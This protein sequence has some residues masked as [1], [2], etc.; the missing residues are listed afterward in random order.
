MYEKI[1]KC[2]SKFKRLLHVPRS[3]PGH[4]LRVILLEVIRGLSATL[5]LLLSLTC[6]PKISLASSATNA[7]S[8]A[9]VSI[10][11]ESDDPNAFLTDKLRVDLPELLL[12]GY[13]EGGESLSNSDQT[14]DQAN[15]FARRDHKNE[16]SWLLDLLNNNHLDKNEALQVLDDDSDYSPNTDLIGRVCMTVEPYRSVLNELSSVE[17]EEKY[18]PDNKKTEKPHFSTE[19]NAFLECSPLSDTESADYGLDEKHLG[20]W[21][22]R[23]CPEALEF[24]ALKQKCVHT[25]DVKPDNCYISAKDDQEHLEPIT[26]IQ[27][28]SANGGEEFTSSEDLSSAFENVD[29]QKVKQNKRYRAMQWA[30]VTAGGCYAPCLDP[31]AIELPR[32]EGKCTW[33]GAPLQQDALSADYFLQC[34]SVHAGQPCGRWA[35]IQCPHGTVFNPAAQ[36]CVRQQGS[37]Q[38]APS[39][40][41]LPR[42]PLGA[43]MMPARVLPPQLLPPPPAIP[44][45]PMPILPEPV[46]F[47]PPA[48]TGVCP[49][50]SVAISLCGTKVIVDSNVPT[51]P[52]RAYCHQGTCCSPVG[53]DIKVTLP[54][55]IQNQAPVC[56]GSGILPASP[57][58]FGCL[59]GYSCQPY[60]GCC[61]IATIDRAPAVLS[62][63]MSHQVPQFVP[64]MLVCPAPAGHVRVRPAGGCMYSPG[65]GSPGCPRGF[66]CSARLRGCCPRYAGR[67]ILYSSSAP[68]SA[69][70]ES[71]EVL[72]CPDGSPLGASCVGGC[73]EGLICFR[74]AHCCP[75]ACPTSLVPAGFCAGSY[76]AFAYPAA[77][78][79][80]GTVMSVAYYPAQI[81]PLVAACPAPA[82]CLSGV[83]CR[84]VVEPA[85]KVTAS[86]PICLNGH[87]AK[88]ACMADNP[89]CGTGYECWS[90]GCCPIPYC[91]SGV[92]AL[93]RCSSAGTCLKHPG[94]TCLDGLCCPTVMC[95]SGIPSVGVCTTGVYNNCPAGNECQNGRC[96]PL[97]LCPNS[98]VAALG[99]C[100][101]SPP[102]TVGLV[103]SP[104]CPVGRTCIQGLC[105]PVV[106]P[107]AAMRPV[108]ACPL[109]GAVPVSMCSPAVTIST[110]RPA[111]AVGYECVEGIGCCALST[112]PNGALALGRCPMASPAVVPARTML[113]PSM[114]GP[115]GSICLNGLCCPPPRC[116]HTG[117]M[118]M[119]MC[120]LANACPVGYYCDGIGCC[121]EPLPV[122]PNGGRSIRYCQRGTEC[123]AGYGCTPMGGCCQLRLDSTCPFNQYPVCQCSS[124]YACPPGA[125][126]NDGGT[127]CA[128]TAGSLF[129]APGSRCRRSADCQ[130][131]TSGSAECLH[132]VCVCIKGGY[133]NGASCVTPNPLLQNMARNG[134][135]QYGQP[136]RYLLSQSRRRP[137]LSPVG[138][139]TDSQPLWFNVA[140]ERD[141]VLDPIEGNEM[142]YDADSTCLP[143]EKCIENRCKMRLWPGEYGCSSDEQCASRCENTYCE[144]KLDHYSRDGDENTNHHS[145]QCQCRDAFLLYGR[146]FEQCPAGFHESGG[147]CQHDDEVA[148]WAD[149]QAQNTLQRLLNEGQC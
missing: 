25:R 138:N 70:V 97:P 17:N 134:C 115:P 119:S 95:G 94:V 140:A 66:Y 58:S 52:G 77:P 144:T 23:R 22:L 24:D 63:I 149:A 67:A 116:A 112:C 128:S 76:P 45:P 64:S 40:V 74:D 102:L 19:R 93:G 117:Q 99:R 109:T 130:G 10:F 47:P 54:L 114:C 85:V 122:C 7:S 30:G 91:P 46:P 101:L 90:G 137:M 96:C 84:P 12:D 135:D 143:N 110:A 5:I 11:Q 81:T 36:L 53:L 35:R 21:T 38:A 131:H 92:Q 14:Y 2:G 86:L 4:R 55:M 59:Q 9:N 108:L 48:I 69:S 26:K 13:G 142:P 3:G 98:N 120:G 139:T 118:P 106:T 111:C 104:T 31:T 129:Y 78:S 37:V 107:V 6:T 145:S 132:N 83:C 49:T 141:C 60:I 43:Q 103:A 1:G 73:S 27:M 61:P 39:T 124:N 16:E 136:C 75:A 105:C 65:A 79:V 51:C 71:R 8:L 123:P 88:V 146:C 41:T 28:D 32:P 87:L 125:L 33:L 56:Y 20:I 121:P 100:S 147:H 148:F 57:C 62:S 29:T 126:C 133:S 82:T 34:A 80:L 89:T 50:N 68:I 113:S 44:P 18:S 72:V 15:D 42:S 127:C